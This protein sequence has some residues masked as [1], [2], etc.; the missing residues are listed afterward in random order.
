MVGPPGVF[1]VSE[2][3]TAGRATCSDSANTDALAQVADGSLDGIVG[4]GVLVLSHASGAGA[5]DLAFLDGPERVVLDDAASGSDPQIAGDRLVGDGA[6]VGDQQWRRLMGC[7]LAACTGVGVESPGDPVGVV[8]G[9]AIPS[10]FRPIPGSP[11]TISRLGE[12]HSVTLEFVDPTG[13]GAEVGLR[14][15][16]LGTVASAAERVVVLG[17]RACRLGETSPDRVGGASRL[18]PS[19]GEI[20]QVADMGFEVVAERGGVQLVD[21]HL[22]H[23]RSQL[24][25]REWRPT[26]RRSDSSTRGPPSPSR[27]ASTSTW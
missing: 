14:L 23:E 27:K 3:Q 8:T 12:P 20:S 2:E 4:E 10:P 19:P 24:G 21:H 1:V 16:D 17:E 5:K 9:R 7:L 26:R 11:L 18:T 25:C 15:C 22:R 13:D 6:K